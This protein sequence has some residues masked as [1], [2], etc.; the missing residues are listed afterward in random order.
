ML[1]FNLYIVNHRTVTG[2]YRHRIL[3]IAKLHVFPYRQAEKQE[4]DKHTSTLYQ[5]L[6]QVIYI[7]DSQGLRCRFKSYFKTQINQYSQ[8]YSVKQ[9]HNNPFNILRQTLS[10]GVRVFVTYNIEVLLPQPQIFNIQEIP[11]IKS[12]QYLQ[13]ALGDQVNLLLDLFNNNFS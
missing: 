2:H 9:A 8:N 10:V 13:L 11:N 5:L 6:Q 12:K 1:Q 4:R 7:I 3:M